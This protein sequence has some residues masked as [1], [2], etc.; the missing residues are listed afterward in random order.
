[1][2]NKGLQVTNDYGWAIERLQEQGR[3]IKKANMAK[4][5]QSFV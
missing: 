4:R 3:K 2:K 5:L 1:M